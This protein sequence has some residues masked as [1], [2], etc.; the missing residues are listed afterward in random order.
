[1]DKTPFTTETDFD[2]ED[3]RY[4]SGLSAEEKLDFVEQLQDF[5]NQAMPAESKQLWERLKEDGF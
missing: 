4:F 1:M 5:L 2:V 3:L